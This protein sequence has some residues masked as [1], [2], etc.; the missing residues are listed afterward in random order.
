MRLSPQS[1]AR[2]SS[3]RPWLVVGIWIAM[4]VLSG[5]LTGSLL[6]DATTQD[7]GLTNEPEAQRAADLIE[8]R[9]RGPERATEI[10]IVSSDSLTVD[11]PQFEQHVRE[12]QAELSALGPEV[13]LNVATFYDTADPSMVSDDRRITI[14]PTTLNS[15][16]YTAAE[17]APDLAE[18][19]EATAG[20]AFEHH[21]FGPASLNEDFNR[22]AEEDLR[23]GETIGV[24]AALVVLVVVFGAV[25]AALLPIVIGIGAIFLSIGVVA[26]VGQITPFSFFVLNMISMIGLA[27]GI[28]YSLFIVSRYREE[29]RKGRDKLDAIEHAGGTA[30]RAVLFSGL[31][32]VLSL[33]GM[34]LIPNTIFRS[35]AAGAI[36]VVILAMAAS[37]TLLPAV[38]GLLGDRINKLHIG[39]R[40]KA[41]SGTEAEGA[42]WDRS[43]RA[44]MRRPVVSLVAGVGVLLLAATQWTAM[45][46]GFAGVS[47]I[48]D[49]FE[50]KQGFDILSTEFS[51]GLASPVEVV[52]DGASADAAAVSVLVERMAADPFLGQP[53]VESNDAGDLTLVSAPISGDPASEEAVAAVERVRNDYVPAAEAEGGVRQILVGGETAFNKDFF[54]ITDTYMPIVFAFVLGLS[55]MLL[56]VAF[57][58]VVVPLKAIILNLLSVGAAYGL[59]VLVFQKGVG[60]DLLG[61]QQVD[62]IE[63]WLPLFLFSVLFGLSMDYHVFLLSRVREHYDHTGDNTESVAHGVRST[64]RII[65][66]AALIMVA[67]FSGFSLGEFPAFQQMG[68]GLAVAVLIDATLIRTVLVPASMKLLGRRNWYL[69]SFLEWLPNVSVEGPQERS[70]GSATAAEPVATAGANRQA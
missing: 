11:D 65:T 34:L 53:R 17:L 54:D 26:L 30:T 7:I 21:T 44:V 25:V 66:G 14:L 50:S 4:V 47:N 38:L 10:V 69:P 20:G 6:E 59:I 9:L 55:F 56:T 19:V 2:A 39:R 35:L 43:V 37:M 36:F 48:S 58:S 28:D 45:E 32:V 64:G 29:R 22:V 70:E 61:F 67:V 52:V 68:F 16:R 33:L 24:G 31:T 1:L 23:T 18:V 49:R 3:R 60:A 27:V 57:R 41:G 63:A 12:V 8:D 5:A 42:F 51:G 62:V 15:G 40:R 46:T 13:V